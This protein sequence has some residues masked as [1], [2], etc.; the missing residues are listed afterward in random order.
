[1]KNGRIA[2]VH[3]SVDPEKLHIGFQ[4][5]MLALGALHLLETESG[6]MLYEA[7]RSFTRDSVATSHGARNHSGLS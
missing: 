6:E 3:S 7:S 1:M 2:L 4:T 5:A